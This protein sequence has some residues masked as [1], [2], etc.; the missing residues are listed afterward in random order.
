MCGRRPENVITLGSGQRVIG[1]P[2]VPA[3]QT[4][5][6]SREDFY[7]AMARLPEWQA[8][9]AWGERV[10]ARRYENHDP[11]DE[12]PAERTPRF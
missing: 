3:A 11:G 12:D 7:R 10:L 5:L 2:C 6:I 9:A 4:F 1:C 8:M